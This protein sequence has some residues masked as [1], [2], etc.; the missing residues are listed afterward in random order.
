MECNNEEIIRDDL[1]AV[2]LI[3]LLLI[4]LVGSWI[5]LLIVYTK[6]DVHWYSDIWIQCYYNCNCTLF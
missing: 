5:K 4:M 2:R 3:T 6:D 1:N